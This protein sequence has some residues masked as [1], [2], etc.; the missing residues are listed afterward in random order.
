MEVAG[1]CSNVAAFSHA[2]ALL[3]LGACSALAPATRTA[4]MRSILYQHSSCKREHIIP[5]IL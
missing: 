5:S 4:A 1:G 2:G 3:S